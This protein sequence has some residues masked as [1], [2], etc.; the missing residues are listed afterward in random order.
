MSWIGQADY[1]MLERLSS[2]VAAD[3]TVAMVTGCV[4][5]F[6]AQNCWRLFQ[7]LYVFRT[8]LVSG[9][10]SAERSCLFLRWPSPVFHQETTGRTGRLSRSHP[11]PVQVYPLSVVR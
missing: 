10:W 7:H 8:R 11:V 9:L 2:K 6:L 3:K 5:M 1:R 4:E